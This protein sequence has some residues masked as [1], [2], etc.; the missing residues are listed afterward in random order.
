MLTT[1]SP[2][3]TR[4]TIQQDGEKP[5]TYH[6]YLGRKK[7]PVVA[8]TELEATIYCQGFAAGAQHQYH[9]TPDPARF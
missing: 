2:D 8:S 4:L 1:S 7:L 3:P 5:N 9:A 6:I